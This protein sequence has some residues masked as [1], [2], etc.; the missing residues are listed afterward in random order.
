MRAVGARVQDFG[1]GRR[2]LS[3]ALVFVVT[4]LT[5]LDAVPQQAARKPPPTLQETGLY[6]DFATLEVDPRHLAF[7]PQYP[8]WT[9]G[10]AK[11]RWISLP[12][13]SAID[14]SDPDAWV[15]PVGTRL[16]K[17]FSFGGPAGGNALHRAPA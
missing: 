7:S 10:A 2:G 15:F 11:R 12:P 4:L 3:A 16:W 6:S 17:E 13:G 14:G 5:S 1:S 8:L 9:D